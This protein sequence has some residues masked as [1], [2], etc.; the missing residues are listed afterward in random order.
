MG[1]FS[2]LRLGLSSLE[3]NQEALGVVSDNL[4]NI[5]TPGYTRKRAIFERQAAG[6]S[7]EMALGVRVAR[8][9]SVR[10][11]FLDKRI[12]GELQEQGRLSGQSF[13]LEQIEGALFT[14][15]GS[16]ISDHLSR[17]FNSFSELATDPSSLDLRQATIAEGT[18]LALAISTADA[19]LVSIQNE[20]GAAAKGAVAE[21]NDLLRQLSD[22][23]RRLAPQVAEGEEGGSL[24]DQQQQLLTEL[25]GQID[26]SSFESEKGILTVV[27]G[28]GQLLLAG[29][30]T[31]ALEFEQ[32]T[33]GIVIRLGAQ[34]ITSEITGGQ[35]GGYLELDRTV[36]DRRET[37]DRLAQELANQVNAVHQG[38]EGMD[39]STGLDFFSFNPGDAASTLSVSLTDPRSVAAAAPGGGA[40]DG[41]TAQQITDLRD[42]A[43]AELNDSTFSSFYSELVYQVGADSQLVR[44]SLDLQDQIVVQMQNDRDSVSAVSLDEEAVNLINFQSFYEAS[45][46]LIQTLDELIEETVNLVR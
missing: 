19:E 15:S 27:T 34:D 29:G 33:G 30:D 42:Q 32:T 7:A 4:A 18:Q 45:A 9:E 17:F 1:L 46:Q 22:L 13:G 3:S 21:V 25:A 43:V 24:R 38:G 40:G 31:F 2:S 35:L 10:S 12:L 41:T 37:L 23:N 11:R 44:E 14:T 20:N 6:Q 8:V 28:S 16:G 26:F 39:G 36:P 5:S